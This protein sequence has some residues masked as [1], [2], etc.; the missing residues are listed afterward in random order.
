MSGKPIR[1]VLADDHPVVLEGLKTLAESHGIVVVATASNGREAVDSYRKHRP[2][3]TLL[4]VRMPVMDG[5][6][7]LREIRAFDAK[8]RVVMLTTYDDHESVYRSLTGGARGYLLKS[9]NAEE[10]ASAVRAVNE[11]GRYIPPAV[12]KALADRIGA[13]QL[14]P[15]ELEVLNLTARGEQNKEIAALLGISAGTV[16]GHLKNILVKLGA[17]DRTEAVT[18]ALQRGILRVEDI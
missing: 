12:S 8:A 1:I 6:E 18:A 3:V 16:K 7:A 17:R 14:T 15:R 13:S 10:I 11:G 4:D 9:A 5:I 2:D